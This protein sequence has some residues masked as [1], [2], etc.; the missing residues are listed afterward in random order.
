MRIRIDKILI[1]NTCAA[2][3]NQ[4]NHG[5]IICANAKNVIT[6]LQEAVLRSDALVVMK[7]IIQWS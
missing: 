6:T 1:R 3:H 2:T 7:M 5:L 4:I